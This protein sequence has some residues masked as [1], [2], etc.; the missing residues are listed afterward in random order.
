MHT[1]I[2]LCSIVLLSFSAALLC[3]GCSAMNKK[4][5]EIENKFR[6]ENPDLVYWKI[7][8]VSPGENVQPYV[9]L[10]PKK[11]SD[12]LYRMRAN[13]LLFVNNEWAKVDELTLF[14]YVCGKTHSCNEVDQAAIFFT[15]E[16]MPDDVVVD[17]YDF[18]LENKAKVFVEITNRLAAKNEKLASTNIKSI[19]INRFYS[20][21]IPVDYSVVVETKTTLGHR[22]F[23]LILG[24]KG[25]VFFLRSVDE[26]H[27]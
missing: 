16:Y 2:K 4:I 21:A 12:R 25:G 27:Q 9:F 18:F 24:R 5:T 14:A 10:E 13:R 11:T 3:G 26:I 8:D 19:D 7:I 1:Q 17:I 20:P 23:G 6:I 22:D 15:D